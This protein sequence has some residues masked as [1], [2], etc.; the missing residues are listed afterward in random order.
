MAPTGAN[1]Q[2]KGPHQGKWK[3][4]SPTRWKDGVSTNLPHKST[5]NAI[6][7]ITQMQVIQNDTNA[8]LKEGG[9]EKKGVT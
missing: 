6:T 1:E 9:G 5:Q 2:Q 3:K 7:T 8:K 4:M